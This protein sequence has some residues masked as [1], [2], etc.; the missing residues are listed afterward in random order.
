MH[1]PLKRQTMGRSGCLVVRGLPE[2]QQA[3]YT[4]VRRRLPG[5]PHADDSHAEGRAEVSGERCTSTPWQRACH[6]SDLSENENTHPRVHFHRGPNAQV[7][8][9]ST[10]LSG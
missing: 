10:A 8:S 9:G 6:V 1:T 5:T 2:V 7:V 3:Q 4:M